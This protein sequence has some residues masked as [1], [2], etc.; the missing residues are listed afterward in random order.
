MLFATVVLPCAVHAQNYPAKP[1]RVISQFASGASGDYLNRLVTNRLAE[2]LGQPVIVE[3]NAGA[4]GSVAT[5]SVA[6]SP[7]DGYTLLNASTGA[8]IIRPALGAKLAYDP[9]KDLAP[10][11]LLG[12]SPSAVL[13]AP[14]LPVN[15]PL[16]TTDFP[17]FTRSL[18]RWPRGSLAAGAT[19]GGA[20]GAAAGV[21]AGG[22]AGLTD[23]SRF[24]IAENLP[25]YWKSRSRVPTPFLRPGEWVS[26]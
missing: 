9:I 8:I 6:R 17:M 3:N 16:I 25:L 15:S 23:S 7:A 18:P 10:I 19:T 12:E 21:D 24:H 5:V 13:V 11:T 1:V 20:E 26:Y 2:L 22:A 14:S 4:G